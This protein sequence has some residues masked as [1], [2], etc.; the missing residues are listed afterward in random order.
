MSVV[1]VT[2]QTPRSRSKYLPH[3]GR[4]E[5]QR[6]LRQIR[7]HRLKGPEAFIAMGVR[8]AAIGLHG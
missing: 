6:R 1:F 4:K 5:C 8:L 3:Q 2:R 7:E